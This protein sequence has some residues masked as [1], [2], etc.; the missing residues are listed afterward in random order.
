MSNCSVIAAGGLIHLLELM[1]KKPITISPPATVLIEGAAKVDERGVKAPLCESIGEVG[2][3][4]LR[5]TTPPAALAD[6]ASD[7]P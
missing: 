7:Q 6:E 2:S 3:M 1:P 4:P 5:A